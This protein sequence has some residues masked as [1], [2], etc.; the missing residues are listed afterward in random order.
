M[1]SHSA[2]GASWS[3]YQGKMQCSSRRDDGRGRHRLRCQSSLCS[4]VALN[5]IV[6]A[7]VLEVGVEPLP[8]DSSVTDGGAVVIPY[9]LAETDQR[10]KAYIDPFA[11]AHA[12]F[13]Q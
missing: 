8:A 5:H 11:L 9:V 12:F 3:G 7:R 1:F 4:M 10:K 2:L 6:H 13:Y